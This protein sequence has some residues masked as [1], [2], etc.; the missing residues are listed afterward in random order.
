MTH[1]HSNDPAWD[2]VVVGGGAAGLGAALQLVRARR[3]VLVLDA[4]EPRNAPAAHLHSYL[5]HDGLPPAELLAL[6]RAEVRSYGGEIHDGRVAEASG[7]LDRGFCV[8]LTDGRRFTARRLVLAMGLLDEL[9]AVPGVREQWGRGVIH[10]PYCHGWEVRDRRIAIVG[11]GPLTTHQALLF[12][13]LSDRVAVALAT[14]DLLSAED[15]ARLLARGVEVADSAA[16]EVRTSGEAVSGLRLADGRVLPADVV[17]VAPR[18]FARTDAVAGLGLEEVDVPM[19][20]GRTLATDG[21]GLTST[22]G[23]YA[24]GNVADASQQVLGAAAD[25]IRIGAVVNADLAMEQADRAVA[26]PGDGAADWDARYAQTERRWTGRPNASLVAEVSDLTPGSAL[27]VGCGEGADAVW[28][29]ERGWKVTGIDIST[30]ALDRARAVAEAAGVS[31]DLQQCDL[32]VNQAPG[33]YDLVSF[34][35]SALRRDAAENAVAAMLAAVAP[36]GRLLVV[37]HCT[38]GHHDHRG[39]FDPDRYVQPPDVERALGPDWV[40]ER[41]EVRA[42]TM[43]AE[44]TGPDVP[45]VILLARRA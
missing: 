24:A 22:A 12:R 30:V 40:V 38:E 31:V 20:N 1:T 43:P 4:G 27:D 37:G 16:V 23:V 6:G 45:D 2:V 5:G 41:S 19:G 32:T 36:G 15:R 9:P 26:G 34:H 13:Q 39:G 28:L 10:C 7:D 14:P 25:G 17:V 21:R 35:Y 29:A 8:E 3:R 33:T 44:Y 11:T 42:R 18:F